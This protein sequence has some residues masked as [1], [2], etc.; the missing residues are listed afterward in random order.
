MRAPR[1]DH[2]RHRLEVSVL[3]IDH[4]DLL[5][6]RLDVIRMRAADQERV[7][8]GSCYGFMEMRDL[9]ADIKVNNLELPLV[10]LE[11]ECVELLLV[12]LEEVQVLLAAVRDEVIRHTDL[13][14]LL[15]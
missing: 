12:V 10:T 14:G 1:D 4:V 9:E 11:V 3:V 2:I 13:E 7:A 15:K 5:E 6:L 8:E